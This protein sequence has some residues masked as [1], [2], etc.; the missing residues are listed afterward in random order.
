M[1]HLPL[2]LEHLNLDGVEN[3]YAFMMGGLCAMNLADRVGGRESIL[4]FPCFSSDHQAR[5]CFTVVRVN[6]DSG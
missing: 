5:M 2:H 4:I 6:K 3:I 1:L